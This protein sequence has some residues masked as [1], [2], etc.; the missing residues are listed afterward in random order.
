[1]RKR[2]ILTFMA[3]FVV[4]S[5]A[6]AESLSS[7][8]RRANNGDAEAQ[9]KLGESYA[10]TRNGAS[11]DK[12]TAIKWFNKA[13]DQGYKEALFDLGLMYRHDAATKSRAI[14]CFE[15]YIDYYYSEHNTVQSTAKNC[16]SELGVTNY[17][18]GT[19]SRQ[20]GGSRNTV[21]GCVYNSNGW[22][23]YCG[24]VKDF[25]SYPTPSESLSQLK[26][27]AEG[28]NPRAQYRLGEYY[29]YGYKNTPT[30]NNEAVR[31]FTKALEQGYEDSYFDLGLMYRTLGDKARAIY[32][33]K[34]DCDHAALVDGVAETSMNCLKDLGVSDY[35]VGST[36]GSGTSTVKQQPAR[37]NK[38]QNNSTPLSQQ[39]APAKPEFM[40]TPGFYNFSKIL[41]LDESGNVVDYVEL[42]GS[43]E[44]TKSYIRVCTDDGDINCKS[45]ILSLQSPAVADGV[46]TLIDKRGHELK[47]WTDSEGKRNFGFES[48]GS[49]I[50]VVL[51]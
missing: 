22:L 38:R 37:D 27:E 1:M 17:V 20:G 14:E 13:L 7:L 15:L 5:A 32:Y 40:L 21:N 9:Y 8:Q 2:I 44:V 35:K 43:V 39:T 46:H 50:A 12:A 28:G 45:E 23:S 4:A 19:R 48:N 16:L 51:D 25:S 26:R 33:F 36:R 31:W 47:A 49:R 11:Y 6:W 30:D 3:A 41:Y 42:T 34:L 29:G 10:Y 18:P 24:P